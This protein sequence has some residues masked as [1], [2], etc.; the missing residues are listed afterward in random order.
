[1]RMGPIDVEQ[2]LPHRGPMLLISEVIFF[3]SQ[4]AATRAVV[5]KHWPLTDATGA[6]AMVLIELV[7]QTAGVSNG[8]GLVQKEGPEVDHRGWIVGIK[9]SRLWVETIPLGSVVETVAENAF[10]YDGL[11]EVR[12]TAKIGG[13]VAAEVTLQLMQAQKNG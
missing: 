2:L 8:W 9:R 5:S 7:A 3:D 10:A 1:M 12:G 4:K 13:Q 11:C 6:N